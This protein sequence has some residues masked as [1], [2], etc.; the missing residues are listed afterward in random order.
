MSS[1]YELLD[2]V[3][4]KIDAHETTTKMKARKIRVYPDKEQKE[5]LY[6]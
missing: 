2:N 5:I 1:L 3:P 4:Q 6:Q